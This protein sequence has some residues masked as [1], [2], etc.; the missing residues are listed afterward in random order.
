MD[1]KKK[2]LFV[3]IENSCRSQMAEGFARRMGGDILEPY[4]AGSN[5]ADEVSPS[6]VAVMAEAGI[7]ISSQKPKGFAAFPAAEF[8]Y[9]VGMGC[10]DTC[11]FFP[12]AGHPPAQETTGLNPLRNARA[13]FALKPFEISR[14]PASGD[15]LSCR[16][17]GVPKGIER[18]HGGQSAVRHIQWDIPDP[19]GKDIEVFRQVRDIIREK[20]A[21][22]VRGA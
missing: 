17:A 7:D 9:L 12:A 1:R 19:K 13:D 5:P 8:D 18:D 15:S 14:C 22:L 11:P 10:S 2:V 4:S 21:E 3:C 20:V 16:Q 6:A